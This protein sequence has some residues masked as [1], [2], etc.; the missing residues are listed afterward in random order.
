MKRI[1]LA[2]TLLAASFSS[3]A[4]E[5]GTEESLYY[6]DISAGYSLALPPFSNAKTNKV[7]L[8]PRSGG[9][10]SFGF[11]R[12]ITDDWGVQVEVLT[13]AFKVKNSDLASAYGAGAS[14]SQISLDPYRSTF[15]GAGMVT[16]RY[17]TKHLTLDLKGSIGVNLVE[18]AKQDFNYKPSQSGDNPPQNLTVS[19]K[20]SLAPGA[21]V[22]GRL[23]YPLGESVDVGI[24]VE[25]GISYANFTN[26]QQLVNTT[27]PADQ[28]PTSLP[29]IKKTVS[30]FNT[31]LTLGLRF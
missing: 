4:Q 9:S 27:N 24:K 12:K 13:T 22:G 23:R 14:L 26:V 15:F 7:F 3:F 2:A 30:Y 20:R 16:N 6:L 11:V 10:M 29:D 31:G 19:A 18:F 5:T 21:L 1:L 8:K 28:M 17:I 25:Y